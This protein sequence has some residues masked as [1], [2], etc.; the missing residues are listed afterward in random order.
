VVQPIAVHRAQF[1]SVTGIYIT[2][3]VI[4]VCQYSYFWIQM[5][6]TEHLYYGD[7]FL[8]LL[9]DITSEKKNRN[10]ISV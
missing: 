6:D 1:L 10:V 9:Y 7:D 8:Y 2:H 5:R 4:G 3:S